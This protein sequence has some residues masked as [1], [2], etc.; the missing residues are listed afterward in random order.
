MDLKRHSVLDPDGREVVFD[1]G[2]HLHLALGTRA[3]LLEHT[4]A[5]LATVARPDHRRHDPRPGRER[6]YRQNPLTPNRWMRVVVDFNDV[7]AWVVTVVIEHGD[8]RWR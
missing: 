8:P 4:E 5:I 6:F 2:S 3:S 7:P 1:G